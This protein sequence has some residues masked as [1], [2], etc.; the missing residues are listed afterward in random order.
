MKKSKNIGQELTLFPA[1]S[2][3]TLS[4]SPAK[5]LSCHQIQENNSCRI[6]PFEKFRHEKDNELKNKFYSLSDHL[7]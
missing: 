3:S 7:D 1:T 4:I 5:K 2:E 6:I